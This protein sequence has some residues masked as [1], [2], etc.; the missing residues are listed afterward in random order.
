MSNYFSANVYV[1]SQ[2][3]ESSLQLAMDMF[4]IMAEQTAVVL[5]R[6][7]HKTKSPSSSSPLLFNSWLK[8]VFPSL[9]IFTDWM[10]CHPSVWLPLPDQLPIEYGPHPDILTSLVKV[11]NYVRQIDRSHIQLG[12]QIKGEYS[13]FN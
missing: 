11:I 3:E 5:E 4:G 9:K 10:T 2:Y 7:V 13:L 12:T 8:Q 6:H 1:R